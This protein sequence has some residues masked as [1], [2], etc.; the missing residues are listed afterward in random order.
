[1][2]LR[3][4]I[5]LALSTLALAA[6]ADQLVLSPA[7]KAIDFAAGKIS[8]IGTTGGGDVEVYTQWGWADCGASAFP[9][10]AGLR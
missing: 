6:P 3:T 1:M 9:Y 2:L 5:L 7:R 8:Q 10:R 4:T